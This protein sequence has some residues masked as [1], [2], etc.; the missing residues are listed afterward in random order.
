MVNYDVAF[1]VTTASMSLG[2]LSGV[3][4]EADS[5]SNDKTLESEPGDFRKYTDWIVESTAHRDATL[6]EHIESISSR[7]PIDRLS[8]NALPDECQMTLVIAAFF[9]D[10]C[11]SVYVPSQFIALLGENNIELEVSCY[12]CHFAE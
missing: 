9:D 8:D 1:R 2:D 6:A 11:C 10:A 7:I 4:G 12:P 3:L 5:I